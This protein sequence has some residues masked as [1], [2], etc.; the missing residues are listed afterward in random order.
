M[1]PRPIRPVAPL[2]AWRDAEHKGI[3]DG[4]VKG[5]WG[6]LMNKLESQAVEITDRPV[7]IGWPLRISEQGSDQ[8]P[9]CSFSQQIIIDMY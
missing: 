3:G 7:G 9:G 4:P 2:P 5:G 1:D 6:H 8:K